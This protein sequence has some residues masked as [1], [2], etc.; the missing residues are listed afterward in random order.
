MLKKMLLK[1]SK[2]LTLLV[3]MKLLR[4]YLMKAEML[5]QVVVKKR[6]QLLQQVQ[7]QMSLV[8]MQILKVHYKI[9]QRILIMVMRKEKLIL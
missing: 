3:M 7:V 2:G 1:M 8:Q 6:Q 5:K 4:K 9:K